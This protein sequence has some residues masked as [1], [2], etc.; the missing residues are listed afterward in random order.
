[1]SRS[2]IKAKFRGHANEGAQK[3][4]SKDSLLRLR[5]FIIQLNA[6]INKQIFNVNS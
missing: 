1:M 5:K 2:L 4:I 6:K 3:I